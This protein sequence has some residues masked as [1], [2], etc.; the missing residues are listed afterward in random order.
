MKK[1][2]VLLLLFLAPI[3]FAQEIIIFPPSSGGGT[4]TL[5]G[6]NT[7]TNTNKFTQ[8][9]LQPAS[10]GYVSA[11][12]TNN[13]ATLATLTGAS[14]TLTS[15]RNYYFELNVI[16]SN[17]V[18]TDGLQI[19]FGGGSVAATNFSAYC[20][21]T[22]NTGT[23]FVKAPLASLTTVCADANSTTST[24]IHVM[25]VIEVS[26]GGT[27]IVRQAANT[28]STGVATYLRGGLLRV[29]DIGS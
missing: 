10:Y 24:Y 20:V 19:D 8:F 3:S 11:N 12:V 28:E 16:A 15:S 22:H 17:T 18:G 6:L 26:T 29:F 9:V 13:T 23:T 21:I 7:W 2:F 25:G 14:V 4:V 5:G 1:M 27:F